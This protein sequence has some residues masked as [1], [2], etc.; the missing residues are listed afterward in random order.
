MSRF[1]FLLEYMFYE[2]K[3]CLAPDLLGLVQKVSQRLHE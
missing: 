2:V 3:D 1:Y